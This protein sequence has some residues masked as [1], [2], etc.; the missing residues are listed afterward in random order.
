MTNKCHIAGVSDDNQLD[1]DVCNYLRSLGYSGTESEITLS[2]E[3]YVSFDMN[4]KVIKNFILPA[5]DE[6]YKYESYKVRMLGIKILKANKDVTSKVDS[7]LDNAKSP[8]HP[9][10]SKCWIFAP[11]QRSKSYLC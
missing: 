7:F 4:R 9:R 1:N 8:E 10:F 6:N 5:L 2:V 11:T 3:D